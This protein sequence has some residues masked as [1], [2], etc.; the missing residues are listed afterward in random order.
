[1]PIQMTLQKREEEVDDKNNRDKERH[2][3][4]CSEWKKKAGI[5]FSLSVPCKSARRS[6]R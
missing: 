5:Y 3:D 2:W 1:M 4:K 6:S